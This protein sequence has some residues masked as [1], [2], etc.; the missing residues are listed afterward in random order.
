M[1]GRR[2]PASVISDFHSAQPRPRAHA[3]S[4]TASAARKTS[5]LCSRQQRPGDR[6]V[7]G[8]V[9]D[10]RGPEVDHGGQ[11]TVPDQQVAGG[12]IAVEPDRCALPR[13]CEGGVPHLLCRVR[14]DAVLEDGYRLAVS[15]STCPAARRRRI[16][17]SGGRSAH[18]QRASRSLSKRASVVANALRSPMFSIPVAGNRAHR[19]PTSRRGALTRDALRDGSGDAAAAGCGA[20]IGSHRCSLSHLLAVALVAGDPHRHVVAERGGESSH[21]RPA[22]PGDGQVCRNAES[23]PETKRRPGDT[24]NGGD[25]VTAAVLHH[26]RSSPPQATDMASACPSGG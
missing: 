26:R 2:S 1:V 24:S 21:P 23:C 12:D 11:P 13:R 15:S 18:T 14:V 8:R 4:S 7:T 19:S 22:R 3:E 16:V 20:R 6:R 9:T 25:G 10:A 17:L 5:R